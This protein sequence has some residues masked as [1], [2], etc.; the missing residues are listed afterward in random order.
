MPIVL[1]DSMQ[2]FS[3]FFSSLGPTWFGRLL[4]EVVSEFNTE[5]RLGEVKLFNTCFVYFRFISHCTLSL[6]LNQMNVYRDFGA[7]SNKKKT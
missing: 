7:N 5:L 3:H 2:A 1:S 4:K 6:M